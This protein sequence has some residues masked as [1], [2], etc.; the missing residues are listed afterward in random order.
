MECGSLHR[1]FGSFQFVVSSFQ[2]FKIVSILFIHVSFFTAPNS[3]PES[4][5]DDR[6]PRRSRAT[7]APLGQALVFNREW[8][9]SNA[10]GAEHSFSLRE[11]VAAGRMRVNGRMVFAQ[12]TV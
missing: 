12:A 5:R 3:A 1:F 4:G 9:R 10:K 2:F 6:T 8:T 7:H 11:K